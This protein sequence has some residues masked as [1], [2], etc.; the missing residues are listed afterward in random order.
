MNASIFAYDQ[1]VISGADDQPPLPPGRALKFLVEDPAGARN[2]AFRG[3]ELSQ[4]PNLSTSPFEVAWRADLHILRLAAPNLAST[5]LRPAQVR[6][7]IRST[8]SR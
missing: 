8:R 4:I 7:P 5:K 6:G 2:E 3:C 1:Q